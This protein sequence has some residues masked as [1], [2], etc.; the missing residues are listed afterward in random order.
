MAPTYLDSCVEIFLQPRPDKGYFN[1]EFNCG[2]SL[3]C[4]YVVD[5]TRVTG[6]F[7]DYTPIPESDGQQITIYHSMPPKVE[8]E[9]DAPTEW[10]LEFFIPFSLFESKVGP[11]SPVSGRAWRANLYKCGDD[12]SH[13]H[14][15]AWAAVDELNFHLPRC[16]G[17]I[18]FAPEPTEG[19]Q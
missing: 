5:P 3:L 7:R 14:W 8:P 19:I 10:C 11:V 9:I 16:F 17:T 13:P 6:G 18:R 4:Y 15:A 2:G 1:F 12:T